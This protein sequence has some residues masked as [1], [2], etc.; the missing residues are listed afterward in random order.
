[1]KM[2][3]ERSWMLLVLCYWLLTFAIIWLEISRMSSDWAGV[4]GFMFTL[5][6]TALVVA[7]YLLAGYAREFHGYDI[8]VTF[9]AL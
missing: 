2:R 4:P 9:R 1:M 8:H 7:A 6:L 5:P 3:L